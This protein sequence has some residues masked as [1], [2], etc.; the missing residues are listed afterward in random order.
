MAALHV[1]GIDFQLGLGEELAVFV[2]KK[3]LADLIAVRLLRTRLDQDLALK[4]AGRAVHQHLLEHLP[5]F[6]RLG[7]MGD[8]HGVV[9]M[10]IAVAHRRPGQMGTGIRTGQVDHRLVPGQ[11]AIR[12]KGKGPQF[13]LRTQPGEK[14]GHRAA[15]VVAALQADVVETGT[16]RN[17]NFQ[18]LVETCSGGAVLQKR[19]AGTGVKLNAVMQDRIGSV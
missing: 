12:G 15:F 10:E 4:D 1:I 16:I 11:A 3:A 19:Q 14:M 17:V 5:A 6:A 13:R 8:E 2:Q 7:P 18:N 9:V